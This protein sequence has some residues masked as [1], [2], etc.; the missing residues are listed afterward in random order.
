MCVG[1]RPSTRIT[2]KAGVKKDG[3]LTALHVRH[4]TSGGNQ[5]GDSIATPFVHVYRCPNLKVEEYTVFLNTNAQRPMRAPG[6][7]PSTFALEGTLDALANAI[8]MDPLELRRK[9]Y[10]TK[11]NGDE[12]I[13]YS[14]KNLDRCYNLGSE[15]ILWLRRR[16]KPALRG[17]VKRGMGMASQIWGGVGNP[18]TQAD[19][20]IHCA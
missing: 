5:Q 1:N 19:I 14:S 4:I 6:H 7:V 9:N 17:K 8:G 11:N 16:P 10:S 13:P 15:K 20:K 2:V 18:V 12:G 3:T